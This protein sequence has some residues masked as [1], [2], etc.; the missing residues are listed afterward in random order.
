MDGLIKEN[1]IFTE[2]QWRTASP[3][4]RQEAVQQRNEAFSLYLKLSPLN[5]GDIKEPI[6]S[7][8]L[9]GKPYS[10]TVVTILYLY[11]LETF[12]PRAIFEVQS[13][14]PK[15][16]ED[17]DKKEIEKRIQNL[18][19][20]AKVLMIIVGYSNCWRGDA[21]L[22]ELKVWRGLTLT[23]EDIEDYKQLALEEGRVNLQGFTSTQVNKEPAI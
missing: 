13:S 10:Q 14:I 2:Q 12:I 11:S 15:A 17:E 6:D 9:T 18:G 1:I 5:K 19:P 8:L 3:D 16:V 20:I 21:I 7:K 22:G 4:I 23:K